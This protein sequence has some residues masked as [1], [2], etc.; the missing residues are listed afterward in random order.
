MN[1][2]KVVTGFSMSLDGFVAGPNDS[3]ERPLGEGGEGL[4]AWYYSGDSEFVFPSGTFTVQISEASAKQLQDQI[5]TAGALV[6]GRRT[7]DI[8]HGWGGRHPMDVP[9]FVVSHRS[10][11][12]WVEAEWPLTFVTD[13]LES[14][15][16]Q[17]RQFAGDKDIIAGS[18][19]IAKQCLQAGLL[20]EF[21]V[22][23]V[24]LLLG[25][26][27]PFFEPVG[28]EPIELQ[29]ISVIQAPG[30]TH[31]RFRIVYRAR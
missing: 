16:E 20:D 17:A 19:S 8:T 21:S 28:T 2:G 26:G 6:T 30:V 10:P 9:V 29:R 27:V 7:F 25:D 12:D 15:I 23:L 24:P 11:P 31:L 18:P 22:D 4:F 13:G 14:A 5:K 3:A 1:M